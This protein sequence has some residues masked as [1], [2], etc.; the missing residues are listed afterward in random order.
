MWEPGIM[1]SF[2][3]SPLANILKGISSAGSKALPLSLRGEA[4]LAFDFFAGSCPSS[5]CY[6]GSD[7]CL[8]SLGLRYLGTRFQISQA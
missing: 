5:T 4:L 2:N 3:N 6:S 8:T 1:P 7:I